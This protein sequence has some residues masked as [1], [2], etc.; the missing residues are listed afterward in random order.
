MGTISINGVLSFPCPTCKAT[1]GNYC[2]DP[3]KDGGFI[4]LAPDNQHQ[5]RYQLALDRYPSK[6]GEH[7]PLCAKSTDHSKDCDCRLSVNYE[8]LAAI[9]SPSDPINPSHYQ[10]DLVMRI[11]EHFGLNEDFPLG[12]VIKYILRHKSK[13]GLEDL[14]KAK[15]YLERKI[16]QLEGTLKGELS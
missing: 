11:I 12:N 14:K 9:R 4:K 13:A 5:S 1:A 8:R 15:W 6:Q 10:G 16:A 7:E 3:L 2:V